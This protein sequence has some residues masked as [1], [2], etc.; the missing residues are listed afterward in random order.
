MIF[1]H[2]RAKMSQN[3]MLVAGR[4]NGR[5]TL[6]KQIKASLAHIQPENHQNVPKTHFWQK[7]PWVTGADPENSER[8]GR[9][10][11]VPPPG[12]KASLSSQEM[13]HRAL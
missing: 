4:V 6:F 9:V 7:A 10:P 13:Q 11:P 2:A 8:G 3:A 5:V 12:M 1:A